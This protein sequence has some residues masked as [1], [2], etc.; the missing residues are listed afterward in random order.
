MG[1]VRH[2]HEEMIGYKTIGGKHTPRQ[3]AELGEF[4]T[5]FLIGSPGDRTLLT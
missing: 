4:S 5:I 1:M 2:R 3:E